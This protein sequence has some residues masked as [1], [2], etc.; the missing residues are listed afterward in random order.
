MKCSAEDVRAL[1]SDPKFVAGQIVTDEERVGL[2]R[3]GERPLIDRMVEALANG[4]GIDT[5]EADVMRAAKLVML[6]AGRQ[7]I[8]DEATGPD[9]AS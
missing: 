7:M 2:H 4:E 3:L 1:M 6:R 9:E 8:I 5:S